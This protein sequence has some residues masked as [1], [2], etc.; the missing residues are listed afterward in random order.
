VIACSVGVILFAL[1]V[2]LWWM[3][4]VPGHSFAGSVP[5]PDPLLQSALEHD[6]TLLARTIGERNTAH[7]AALEAA[8]HAIDLH[9]RECGL[10]PTLEACDTPSTLCANIVATVPGASRSSQIVV[11]GAHYDSIIGSPGANDNATGVA[12]LLA[13][14]RRFAHTKPARTLRFVAFVNEEPPY[15]RTDQMGSRIHA[16]SSRAR[17]D[18]IVAMLS[19]ETLGCYSDERGSQRYPS[20]L[21]RLVYPSRGNFVTFVS[22]LRSRPLLRDVVRAFREHARIPS[23]GGALP[24]WVSGVG[25]SDHES[26]WLEDWPAVMVTDTAVFRDP[27]YHRRTDDVEHVGFARLAL[28][29][30]GLAAVVE[31]LANPDA[32]S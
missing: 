22:D 21:L 4:S 17:G 18:D 1:A 28:V 8:R 5:S 15:F 13:L 14:A 9:L 16:L 31:K 3:T 23:E 25:W 10:T 12:A 2:A 20:P 27:R 19:L 29:V 7:P 11:L 6:V 24:S 32:G 30:E 26:F